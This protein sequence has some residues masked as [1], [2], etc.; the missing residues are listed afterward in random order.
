MNFNK[1]TPIIMI[2]AL[3]LLIGACTASESKETESVNSNMNSEITS[4]STISEESIQN[5]GSTIILSE[6][7]ALETKDMFTDRDLEQSPD[8][9]QA[10]TIDLE[11]DREYLIEEEGIYLIRGDVTNTMIKVAADDEAKVQLVLDSV[12][13]V[14][15]DQP[16][17]YVK[18]GDKIYVTTSDSDNYLEVSDDCEDDGDINLD[19]V[20]F[21][22]SDL[23]LNGSG[24]LEV[25]AGS[26]NGIT[27][28]DDMKITSGKI[29]INASE[30]GLEAN[31]SIRIYDGDISIESGKD[32]LKIENDDGTSLGYIYIANG[33]LNLTADYDAIRATGI[34]QIDGGTINIESCSEGI[35]GTYV[36][37]NGGDI[38]IYATDDGINAAKK[39][40]YDVVI[41]IY[42]GN[43]DITMASGDTDA[44]DSNGD[45]L[46]YGG[47]INIEATSAFDINGG[48]AVAELIGGDITVNGETITVLSSG[49]SGR[50]HKN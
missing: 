24:N 18:S 42:D 10:S 4:E 35:E 22:K 21:S 9:S 37:I 49:N 17:I 19:A 1:L 7:S 15:V 34:V 27:S 39:S 38:S 23:V 30:D 28:K 36:Q 6:E 25:V 12:S 50:K 20:I 3:T 2:G 43:I 13:I 33:K 11:S 5:L 46:V 29:V 26:G 41:E 8:L 31:D 14:N 48:T 45:I 47:T 32:A 44:I 40:D 16:A